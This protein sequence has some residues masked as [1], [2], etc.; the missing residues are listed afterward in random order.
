[1]SENES[2][3]NTKSLNEMTRDELRKVAA[4]L[5]IPG[6][7]TMLKPALVEA[8]ALER[9]ARIEKAHRARR[10]NEEI[11]A[12][13]SAYAHTRAT[14]APAPVKVQRPGRSGQGVP[15]TDGRRRLNYYAQNG[16]AARFTPRQRRRY[17]K[18]AARNAARSVGAR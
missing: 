17:A 9:A 18:K 3:L 14:E 6:R 12:Q 4:E 8:I 13:I 1:M 16:H 2:N 11:E 7:G 5:E 15:L 10:M